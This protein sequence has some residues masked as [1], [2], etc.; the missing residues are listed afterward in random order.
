[1]NFR[2][3]LNTELNEMANVPNPDEI[4]KL[5]NA[6]KFQEAFDAMT[7]QRA[8]KKQAPLYSTP[9]S[10]KEK[11]GSKASEF[12]AFLN[13]LKTKKAAESGEVVK[14]K[15]SGKAAAKKKIENAKEGIT[16]VTSQSKT[17]SKLET[18]LRKIGAE[19][20]A[21]LDAA[22]TPEA[23]E[24][25]QLHLVALEVLGNALVVTKN[26]GKGILTKVDSTK[27]KITK[28]KITQ[29][30]LKKNAPEEAKKL[31]NKVESIAREV[32][33]DKELAKE[34]EVKYG[35]TIKDTMK[36]AFASGLLVPRADSTIPDGGARNSSR[37]PNP[38]IKDTIVK[39]SK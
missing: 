17:K 26:T 28:N 11:I 9:G 19:A 2:E 18:K 14:S 32:E 33:L 36:K 31:K 39:N 29:E 5:I 4:A 34:Y 1:M 23:K 35:R 30:Y 12:T 25:A 15:G 3:L 10:V 21:A 8:V 37:Y 20:K 6:D 13:G 24:D 38:H 7:K 16:S 27:A 22:D